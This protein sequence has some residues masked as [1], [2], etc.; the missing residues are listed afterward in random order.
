[1]WSVILWKS[2]DRTLKAASLKLSENLQEVFQKQL[3]QKLNTVEGRPDAG[4]DFRE[5]FSGKGRY[6]HV[7]TR[8]VGLR[9]LTADSENKKH[10]IEHLR[11]LPE[12]TETWN[13]YRFL[14]PGMLFH[15]DS[16]HNDNEYYLHL[17][18][19]H[20]IEKHGMFT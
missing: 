12:S 9:E 5:P 15:E 11:F 4:V 18:L 10:F 16:P 20:V 19:L 1:M 14:I 8:E 6:I 7:V 3:E 17:T 13:F 2:A